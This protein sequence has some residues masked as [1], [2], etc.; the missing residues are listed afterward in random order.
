MLSIVP[1]LLAA[2]MFAPAVEPFVEPLTETAV[3][4][5]PTRRIRTTDQSVRK[6]LKRGYRQSA[7]FREMVTRLQRSDIFVYVEEVPRLPGALEGRLL[8]LPKAHGHR[9]V[10]I[11]LALRGSMEDSIALLGHE[12][13]HAVEI[14]DAVEVSD[15]KDME[16]LYVRIGV[17]SGPHIYDTV[18]AQE[19]GR[20]VRRELM[21]LL[22]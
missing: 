10:R 3:M 5:A 16:A 8:M 1:L 12:L 6:L 7:T 19:M 22:A 15:E 20:R 14:A 9:Y 13:Q 18:A 21:L 4:D 17:R 11:Q 2:V